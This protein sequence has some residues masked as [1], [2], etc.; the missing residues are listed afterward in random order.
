MPHSERTPEQ[1]IKNMQVPAYTSPGGNMLGNIGDTFGTAPTEKNLI[2]GS[3]PI[4]IYGVIQYSDI[5]GEYHE[6]GY[7]FLRVFRSTAFIGCPFGTWFEE[8]RN[9]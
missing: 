4:Y 9:S 7:C 5:F 1:T 2:D 8:R 6:A 3:V